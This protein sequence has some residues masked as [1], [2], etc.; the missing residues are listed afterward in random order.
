[1][2]M[3]AR[4]RWVAV[5]FVATLPALAQ[6]PAQ[7]EYE[8]QQREYWR[9]QEQQR[10]AERVRQQQQDN[11]RRQQEE[12]NRSMRPSAPGSP[13]DAERARNAGSAGAGGG[14]GAMPAAC[15][16]KPLAAGERNPLLGKWRPEKELEGRDSI[17]KLM[18]LPF[19]GPCVQFQL[20][21]E[22]RERE[23]GTAIAPA[24]AHYVRDGDDWLV[25]LPAS[26]VKV[27]RFRVQDPNRLLFAGQCT[28]VREGSA[29][30]TAAT[31]APAAVR[32]D[33]GTL[34][35]TTNV[36]GRTL[37][38][39]RKGIDAVLADAGIV[40]M[41]GR[42]RFKTWAHACES[43][44]PACGMGNNALLAATAAAAKTDTGGNG[45]TPALP[46]GTYYVFGQ[47]SESAMWNV[48]VDLK[49]GDN[50]VKLDAR[51]ATPVD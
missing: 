44:A 20:G 13:A 48:R 17:E 29:A 27:L 8:R 45:R 11:A 19:A 22:F 12:F 25:C 23:I 31:G 21:I 24:P 41:A 51:N 35:L 30:A 9:A 33:S 40:P 26:D 18:R 46:V 4:T 38:V 6:T 28:L 5:L 34:S 36:T 10:E 15:R 14:G 43:G 47:A 49:P 39:L 50:T 32:T 7:M 42:S 2:R 16:L 37:L 3:S 1:M